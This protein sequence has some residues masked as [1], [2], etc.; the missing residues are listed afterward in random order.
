MLGQNTKLAGIALGLLLLIVACSPRAT[1][2]PLTIASTAT[3][4][5]A[6]IAL[7]ATQPPPTNA[8]VATVEE[9]SFPFGKY[10][11]VVGVDSTSW[12]FL[13]DGRLSSTYPPGEFSSAIAT[14][15]GT[16]TVDGHQITIQSGAC[17]GVMGTYIWTDDGKELSFKS[18]VDKC[19]VREGYLEMFKYVK[20][21]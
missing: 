16:Y 4:P 5:P 8:P 18:I 10:S 17:P 9:G 2:P 3:R 15:P 1:Q 11:A 20:E 19:T 21:P 7:T 14:F 13:A 12:V 6:A